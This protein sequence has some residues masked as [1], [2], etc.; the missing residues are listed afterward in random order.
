[1]IVGEALSIYAEMIAARNF[2]I[3]NNSLLN[4]FF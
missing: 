4:V 1:L 2:N 3:L